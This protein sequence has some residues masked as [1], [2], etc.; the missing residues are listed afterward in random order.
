MKNTNIY[1]KIESY[2]I[3]YKKTYYIADVM[4]TEVVT[5]HHWLWL[6]YLQYNTKN[7]LQTGKNTLQKHK[8]TLQNTKLNYKTQKH[9]T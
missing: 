4:E 2:T 7:T 6:E 3:K 1:Y 8:N 9:N 5:R